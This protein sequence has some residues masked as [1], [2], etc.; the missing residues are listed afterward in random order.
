MYI[1]QITLLLKCA[2]K[3][4]FFFFSPFLNRTEFFHK[5]MSEL[6]PHAVISTSVY[7]PSRSAFVNAGMEDFPLW[8]IYFQGTYEART[9]I[10]SC[11][12]GVNLT[13]LMALDF[14]DPKFRDERLK[15]WMCANKTRDLGLLCQRHF[16]QASFVLFNFPSTWL[17]FFHRR[18]SCVFTS[19]LVV[20]LSKIVIRPFYLGAFLTATI[21]STLNA[22]VFFF[23]GTLYLSCLKAWKPFSSFQWPE[24]LPFVLQSESFYA[25]LCVQKLL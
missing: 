17:A 7:Q 15:A 21:Q 8:G 23:K 20:D 4:I 10:C 18:S 11:S 12:Y 2:C 9:Q 3:K 6:Q 22:W 1:S 24:M 19:T 13:N 16:S 14:L 25:R 5:F